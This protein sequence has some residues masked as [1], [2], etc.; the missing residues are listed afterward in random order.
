MVL[1]FLVRSGSKKRMIFIGRLLFLLLLFAVLF[2]AASSWCEEVVSPLLVAKWFSGD[3]YVYCRASQHLKSVFELA[4][5]SL[6]NS[7]V[8]RIYVERLPRDFPEL[9]DVEERK[10]FFL[11]IILPMVL[12][13]E[14]EIQED[15]ELFEK[16]LSGLIAPESVRHLLEKYE[17]D[18]LDPKLIR[19]RVKPVPVWQAL[20]QA[21][22]E[23]GWG[24]SRFA[25]HANNLM[26]EQ[27][28]EPGSGLVPSDRPDDAK[29]EVRVF[30][31]LLSAMRR[32][33]N[34]LNTHES[35]RQYR[36]LRAQFDD[37]RIL[38]GL[39]YYSVERD[40]YIEKLE[41]LINHEG[42]LKYSSYRLEASNQIQN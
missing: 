30:R 27:V 12:K 29:Y 33:V 37:V 8:P 1:S 9:P 34:N 24:T 7:V 32:Y 4:G 10:E 23:S 26:G 15:A 11:M 13:I 39:L 40:K 35:Y 25:M 18:E 2:L 19:L 31:S 3:R 41:F 42:L 20:A 16:V 22:L 36:L 6:G 38:E 5:W 14:E 21:A 28:F 17:L